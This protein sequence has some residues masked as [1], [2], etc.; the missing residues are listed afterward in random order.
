MTNQRNDNQQKDVDI[1]K[2][3]KSAAGNL[4]HGAHNVL[5]TAENAAM[6]SVDTTSNVLSNLTGNENETQK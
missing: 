3:I 5:E 4:F 2:G 1:T 6:N